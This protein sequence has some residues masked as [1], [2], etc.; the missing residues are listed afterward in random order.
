[1]KIWVVAIYDDHSREEVM[2]EMFDNEAAAEEYAKFMDGNVYGRELLSECPEHVKVG[3]VN[4]DE[5]K[6][7]FEVYR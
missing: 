6:D 1:M 2:R 5:E 3:T 7:E 4:E